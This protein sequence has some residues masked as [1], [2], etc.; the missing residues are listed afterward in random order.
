MTVIPY[1]RIK[2]D[3][4]PKSLKSKKYLKESK[5]YFIKNYSTSHLPFSY[6]AQELGD[7]G[8]VSFA[9]E[10]ALKIR[11]TMQCGTWSSTTDK[12]TQY[13]KELPADMK[14]DV[15]EWWKVKSSSYPRL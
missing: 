1:P 5:N 4:T 7:E 15:L 12:L 6:V 10:I 9:E 8:G 13:F 3:L 11:E 14:T 2:L